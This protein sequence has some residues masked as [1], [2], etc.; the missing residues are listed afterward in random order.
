MWGNHAS[1]ETSLGQISPGP[2]GGLPA[3]RDAAGTIVSDVCNDN[4]SGMRIMA[5]YGG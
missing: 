3:R 5:E 2:I 1:L 4:G